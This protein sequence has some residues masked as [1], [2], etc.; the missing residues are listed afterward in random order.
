[1]LFAVFPFEITYDDG[2]KEVLNLRKERW[3]IL[4]DN[5]SDKKYEA[6]L[7]CNAVSSVPSTKKRAK[8]PQ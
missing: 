7:Q 1:M 5:P 8:V 4:E 6:D 2:E 3:E